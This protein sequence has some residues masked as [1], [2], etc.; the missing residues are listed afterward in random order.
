MVLYGK[1]LYTVPETKIFKPIGGTSNIDCHPSY[2]FYLYI[3]FMGHHSSIG[4]VDLCIF[5]YI[6]H[7]HFYK[8]M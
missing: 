4:K 8:I 5:Q 6:T 2:V 7:V 3:H 1:Y